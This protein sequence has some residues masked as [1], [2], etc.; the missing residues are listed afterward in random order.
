MAGAECGAADD[1]FYYSPWRRPG[2]APVIDA[3][4]SAG[5]RLAGQG[6]G[7]YGAQF[8][9][10]THANIGDLGSRGGGYSVGSYLELF[11][12]NFWVFRQ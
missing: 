12:A 11:W 7:G 5:G 10:T 3:C 2:S 6:A 9:N 4:G 8:V 1:F